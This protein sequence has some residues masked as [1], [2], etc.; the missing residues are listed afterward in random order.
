VSIPG[1]DAENELPTLIRPNTNHRIRGLSS[2]DNT[3]GFFIT[4]V[5]WDSYNTGRIDLQ[6]GPNSILFGLGNPSGVIN[7]TL[8]DANFKNKGSFEAR[9]GSYGSYRGSL[10]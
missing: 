6:R 8:N 4:D 7:A 9:A 5:P 3:R 1:G 10:D 2:A